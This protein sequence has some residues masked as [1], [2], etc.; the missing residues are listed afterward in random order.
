MV[1]IPKWLSR[2]VS[3]SGLEAVRQTVAE[4]EK[5]TSVEIVPMV[6]RSSTAFE[7]V[8]V[9]LTLILALF[10]QFFELLQNPILNLTDESAIEAHLF[11]L[12]I[13]LV[14]A[15]ALAFLLDQSQRVRKFFTPRLAM[16]RQVAQRAELEFFRNGLHHTLGGTGV[17]IFV[18][19]VERQVIVLADEEI[20]KKLPATTWDELV[21]KL[22]ANLKGKDLELGFKNAIQQLTTIVRPLFPPSPGNPNEISDLVIV[23]E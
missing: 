23:K 13:Y 10:I 14:I 9:Q 17:L 16:E 1:M 4:S 8:V 19:M 18:S 2:Y 21:K 15:G 22:I 3:E 20:S 11:R 6:V 12:A 7:S 5:L